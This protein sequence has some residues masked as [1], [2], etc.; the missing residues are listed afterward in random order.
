[1]RPPSDE[2]DNLTSRRPV[3][4]VLGVV[5]P[6]FAAFAG[7]NSFPLAGPD[8]GARVFEFSIRTAVPKQR[9]SYICTYLVTPV[10]IDFF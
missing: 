10:A 3:E 7:E 9:F 1:V 6:R 4:P 5:L 2:V 8:R